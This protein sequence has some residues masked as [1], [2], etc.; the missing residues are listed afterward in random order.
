MGLSGGT[1]PTITIYND[2]KLLS[3]PVYFA[4]RHT[5][6]NNNN[7]FVTLTFTFTNGNGQTAVKQMKLGKNINDDGT[8]GTYGNLS[9]YR[10][11][12][13][14]TVTFGANDF[15]GELSTEIDRIPDFSRVGYKYGDEAIPT[16]PVVATIDLASVS[17][18]L[19]A[20]TA[21]D[22][23][24]FFQK[25]IDQVGAA[26]GGAIL[27]KNGTY[28]L[29]R[30]LFLD[31]NNVVLRGESRDN[32]ILYS[33][34]YNGIPIVYIGAT[35]AWQ[36]GD[37]ESSSLT[38]IAGRRVGIS[39]LTAMGNTGASSYGSVVLVSYSPKIDN[40]SYGS[41][42]EINEDYVPLGRLFVKVANPGMFHVGEQ[43]LIE[44][45]AT[46]AWIH[47]IGM[48]KIADNGRGSTG[49]TQQWVTNNYNM[50]WTRVITAIEGN[51]VYLDAPVAHSL[52]ARYG[53]AKLM[54]YTFN[55]VSGCGV[56]NLTFDNRYDSS[57]IYNGNKV[58]EQ[59]AWIGVQFKAAQH[60]WVRN[61]T[62][63]HL[64]YGL[65][66]MNNGAR[67]ITVDNCKCLSPVSAIQGARRYAFCFTGGSELCLVKDCYCEYDRHSF[68]TNGTA[69]GPNVF[70]NCR[71]EH[72]YNAIGPHYGYA[73]A[74][75]Y[76]CILADSEFAA[77][78]GG[79][80]GTGH[81]WRGVNTVFWNVNSS[82]N[83]IVCQSTWG[84]C[85]ECGQ[86][87][88]RTE[89]CSNCGATVIPA[90]RNYAVG[91]VGQKKARTL[92]WDSDYYGNHTTDYF[93]SL[94]GYGT[95][96]E[97]RPDGAWYPERAYDS[98]GG[99]YVTL[100]SGAPVSWWPALNQDSYSSP[101]S[102][103]Q[104]QLEDRHA[105]G[106]YLNNL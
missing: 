98:T 44:R 75:L 43:V 11:N 4:S 19:S 66:D 72:G 23:T 94:Y 51:K 56:E 81:G 101:Y 41:Y 58:D 52:E 29:S 13:L 86:E 80:Q 16:R 33:T 1:S 3:G 46:D 96:G 79:C 63:K 2:G 55:R 60:C 97:N 42:S 61:V 88:N 30:I 32:T 68:V 95:Y 6:G 37:T 21:Q 27:I 7:G 49:G 82:G 38:N 14:G 50:R 20:G 54:H 57:V 47:S 65:A 12:K 53:G 59:H 17:S 73:S 15:E 100:P 105:R 92:N 70:T 67:C 77:Q 85:P 78:D 39:R 106:I 91:V 62:S 104:C 8:A 34:T 36:S 84:T 40:K 28:N 71:S 9:Q 64:V 69:L 24:D 45:R 93:V 22:T 87:Y 90:A 10:I 5:T 31:K 18:A 26:G 48:D 103:Y 76:D 102:L 99:N 25:T 89:T 83:P 35:Q 74:T